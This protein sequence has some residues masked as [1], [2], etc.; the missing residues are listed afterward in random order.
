MKKFTLAA[1]LGL[2]LLAAGQQRASAH[3]YCINFGGCGFGFWTKNSAFVGCGECCGCPSLGPWYLYWPHN[4]HFQTP[5]PT[6]YP[7][8]PQPMTVQPGFEGG[9]AGGGGGCCPSYWYGH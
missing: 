3:G 5:A 9:H 8:W 1:V 6:G 2:C 7:F 4:A